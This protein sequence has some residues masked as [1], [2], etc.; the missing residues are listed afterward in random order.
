MKKVNPPKG[1]TRKEMTQ[2]EKDWLKNFDSAFN[3]NDLKALKKIS[4]SVDEVVTVRIAEELTD[5][6]NA[7]RRDIYENQTP[8][9]VNSDN[10]SE[11]QSW[12]ETFEHII[13]N[14]NPENF[15]DDDSLRPK[16]KVNRYTAE[17]YNPP[18]FPDEDAMNLAID[19]DREIAEKKKIK[20]F[21]KKLKAKKYDQVS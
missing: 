2:E 20:K 3:I 8:V 9:Y 14:T 19:H 13:Q 18:S 6:D 4:Q 17:D 16:Q 5:A 1:S 10:L 11:E 21:P 7:R 12:D 15:V